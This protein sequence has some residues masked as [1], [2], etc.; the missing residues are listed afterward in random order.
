MSEFSASTGVFVADIP[1]G[2]N[3]QKIALD[4][5]HLWVS[6]ANDGTVSEIALPAPATASSTPTI[7]NL[8]QSA[9]YGS[10]FTPVVA[11]NG[12]GTKSV[13]SSTSSVCTVTAGVVH[14]VGVGS[15]SLTAAVDQGAT[16]PVSYTHLTLPTIY[17]V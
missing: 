10:S 14:F 2:G 5:K 6:N 7:S 1:V 8:P 15:C 17:S 16:H 4:T 3:P 11:T 9:A 13:T 12:D